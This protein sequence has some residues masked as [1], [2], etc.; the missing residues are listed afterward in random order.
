MV[1]KIAGVVWGDYLDP[2]ATTMQEEL[3]LPEP[4]WRRFGR[5]H[6]A[7]YEGVTNDVAADLASYLMERALSLWDCD[8]LRDVHR[9]AR[10]SA[11]RIRRQ[12]SEEV[13]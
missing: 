3:G 11:A 12:L 2:R 10:E 13:A 4:E 8:E 6:Q 7:V 9:A 5:G 1:I